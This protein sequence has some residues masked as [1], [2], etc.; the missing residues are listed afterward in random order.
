MPDNNH[1]QALH[2]LASMAKHGE[3][4]AGER[5]AAEHPLAESAGVRE[6]AGWARHLCCFLD[7]RYDEETVKA[8][9]MDC[10]CGPNGEEE[11][12]KALYAESDDPSVFAEKVNQL[13]LGYTLEYD[14]NSFCMVYPQCYCPCAEGM[15]E[16]L[17]RAWCYCTLGYNRKMFENIT[18]RKVRTELIGSIMQGDSTC[19]IRITVSAEG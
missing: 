15:D 3:R 14:G 9:R 19:R 17:P 2:F 1:P 12:L 13:D 6:T 5:F 7:G 4:E 16:T 10:A 11:P 8:I 18:G